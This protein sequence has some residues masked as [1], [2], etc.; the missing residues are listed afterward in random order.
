MT[1][2][3]ELRIDDPEWLAWR[4]SG[5]TASDVANAYTGQYGGAYAVV[6]SKLD[7][8]PPVERTERMDRGHRWE[9]R[10]ADAVHVL[11]GLYVHGEQTWCQNA[12]QPLHRATIDG[13][14]SALAEASIDDI[15]ALLETK[16]TGVGVR[17]SWDAWSVQCQWQMWCTGM[18]RALIAWATID[19]TD[20]TMTL[21]TF[22]WVDRDEFLIDTLVELATMLW[23]HVT[24]GTLPEP[25]SPSALDTVKEVNAIADLDA[26]PVDLSDM[27]DDLTRFVA[28]KAAVKASEGERDVLEARLRDRLGRATKGTADGVTVSLSKPRAVFTPEAETAFLDIYPDAKTN[29]TLDRTAAKKLDKKLYDELAQPIGARA[30]IIKETSK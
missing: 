28:L 11:T 16:T 4:K 22:R 20:D 12:G 1:L 5:I 9:Q 10:I 27:A 30:L 8:L 25:N 14:L 21:L 24:D 15:E 13:M 29:T 17:P 6:A 7:L 19:D 23:G 26:L 2:A 18:P 3:G